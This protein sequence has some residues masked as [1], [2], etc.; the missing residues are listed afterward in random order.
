MGKICL[1][2]L[3]DKQKTLLSQLS[4]LDFDMEAYEKLKNGNSDITISDLQSIL[5]NPNEPY[6]GDISRGNIF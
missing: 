2:D 3:N 6:L 1:E 4:Y 5:S